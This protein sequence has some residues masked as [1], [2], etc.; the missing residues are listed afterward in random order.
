MVRLGDKSLRRRVYEK[1][2]ATLLASPLSMPSEPLLDAPAPEYTCT[3]A[4]I[5]ERDFFLLLLLFIPFPSF[6]FPGWTISR[7]MKILPPDA[8]QQ[9]PLMA[10]LHLDYAAPYHRS[11]RLP[12][13]VRCLGRIHLRGTLRLVE[14]LPF[15]LRFR[16]FSRQSNQLSP[17]IRPTFALT[18]HRIGH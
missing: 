2:S 9:A 10:A 1:V 17:Y 12:T 8:V 7:P 13:T 4:P 14:N 11:E 16:F 5:L 18:P 15:L 3:S 6:D